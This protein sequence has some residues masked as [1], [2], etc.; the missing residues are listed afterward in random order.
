MMKKLD[1][2]TESSP[3]AEERKK[4]IFDSMSARN[5]KYI[6]KKG[7]ENDLRQIER[8][9]HLWKDII[10]RSCSCRVDGR[11]DNGRP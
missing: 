1:K 7:Y 11:V 2:I 10:R 3:E 4:A 5:R 6:E 9:A 8:D